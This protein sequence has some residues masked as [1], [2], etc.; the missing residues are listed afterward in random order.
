MK[1]SIFFIISVF[2]KFVIPSPLLQ[3]QYPGKPTQSIPFALANF[4]HVPYG[5]NV[6]GDIHVS[7]PVNACL[8]QTF[9]SHIQQK[10]FALAALRGN[11][12]FLTKAYIAQASGASMLIVVDNIIEM[13]ENITPM[14]NDNDDTS[15]LTIPTLFIA[16]NDGDSLLQIGQKAVINANASFLIQKS[17]KVNITFWLTSSQPQSIRFV[18]SFEEYYNG[19]MEGKDAPSNLEVHY[20]G[21][22]HCKFCNFTNY[23]YFPDNCISG[24]RFC[25]AYPEGANSSIAVNYIYEDLRQ[26]CIYNTEPKA[27]WRYMSKFSKN[28]LNDPYNYEAC[29]M[30]ILKKLE[31]KLN[32]P[33]LLQR[34]LNCFNGSFIIPP[35]ETEVDTTLQDNTI[36][37]EERRISIEKGIG[38][39]PMVTINDEVYKGSLAG[40]LVFSAVCEGFEKTPEICHVKEISDGSINYDI[41]A[42]VLIMAA[43]VAG[44]VT[45]IYCTRH[46]KRI[47]AKMRAM[48]ISEIIGKYH[49]LREEK[50]NLA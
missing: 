29:S 9:A 4:G 20:T 43:F 37:K 6:I 13:T 7:T 30:T 34:T 27:W 50:N 10:P 44:V 22:F 16:K 28:C 31:R 17:P 42:M 1:V 36:L 24:G 23:T 15:N 8:P 19:M 48:E 41:I 46:K 25:S 45:I 3:L 32:L 18:A 38:F 39:W 35:T 21:L 14:S 11:C 47:D 5:R 2:L 49:V 26:K 40:D 33:N 12:S